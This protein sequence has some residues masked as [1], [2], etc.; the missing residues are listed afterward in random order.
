MLKALE[1]TVKKKVDLRCNHDEA[2]RGTVFEKLFV[3]M[4][5]EAEAMQK[6]GDWVC[7]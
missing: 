6:H 5:L 4:V 2:K 1:D 7:S 3:E